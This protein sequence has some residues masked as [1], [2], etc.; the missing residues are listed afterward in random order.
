MTGK[1]TTVWSYDL[2]QKPHVV[3]KYPE[4]LLFPIGDIP[5]ISWYRKHSFPGTKEAGQ[6]VFLG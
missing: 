6:D 3:N 4:I 1:V 2:W 5:P